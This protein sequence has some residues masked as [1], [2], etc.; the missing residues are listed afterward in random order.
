MISS[1][2]LAM[3]DPLVSESPRNN[4]RHAKPRYTNVVVKHVLQR[5]NLSMNFDCL[6]TDPQV[7]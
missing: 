1:A 7:L 5:S 2:T 3:E 4:V 6:Q